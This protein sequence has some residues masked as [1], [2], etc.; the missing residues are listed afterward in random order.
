MSEKELENPAALK[1]PDRERI[2]A[3]SGESVDEIVKMLQ[4]FQHTK[5]LAAWLQLK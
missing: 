4:Y 5:I 3:S 2:A 1:G